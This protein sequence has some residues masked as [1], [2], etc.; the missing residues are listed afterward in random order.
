MAG[1]HDIALLDRHALDALDDVA[2]VVG[3]VDEQQGIGPLDTEREVELLA[4]GVVKEVVE[5][6]EDHVGVAR[7]VH[8]RVVGA[9]VA[10]EPG[11]LVGPDQFGAHPL[12]PGAEGRRGY[13]LQP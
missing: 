7:G 5:V 8:H 12:R 2:A 6:H 10:A 11:E 1:L 9:D 13:H 4:D 3:L